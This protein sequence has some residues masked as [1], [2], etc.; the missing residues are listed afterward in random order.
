MGMLRQLFFGNLDMAL[1]SSYDPSAD[2]ASP[3]KLQHEMAPGFTVC[4]YILY[5]YIISYISHV[6][7]TPM[8][9]IILDAFLKHLS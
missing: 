6:P 4:I 2:G 5:I 7:Y 3:F 1:H 8:R 9:R